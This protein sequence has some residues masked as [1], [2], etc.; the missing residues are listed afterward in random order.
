MSAQPRPELRHCIRRYTDKDHCLDIVAACIRIVIL[1]VVGG[2]AV[3]SRAVESEIWLRCG[4]ARIKIGAVDV[5]RNGLG[6][7]G[8]NGDCHVRGG[9]WRRYGCTADFSRIGALAV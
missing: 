4:I 7:G 1:P 9:W 8:I 6:L 2:P 3:A 5:R